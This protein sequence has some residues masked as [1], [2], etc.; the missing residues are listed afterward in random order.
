MLPLR[1]EV[2]ID[3]EKQIGVVYFIDIEVFSEITDFFYFVSLRLQ[4]RFEYS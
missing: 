1:F 4:L 2:E 3:S